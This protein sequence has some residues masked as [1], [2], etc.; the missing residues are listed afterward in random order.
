[1]VEDDLLRL[2]TGL[3]QLHG[4]CM[5]VS[6][7][8]WNLVRAPGSRAPSPSASVTPATENDGGVRLLERDEVR[9]NASDN[10]THDN[11]CFATGKEDQSFQYQHPLSNAIEV[12]FFLHH[13][14]FRRTL[15][16][17][18]GRFEQASVRA[19]LK[20]W[21]HDVSVVSNPNTVSFLLANH[22][23]CL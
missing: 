5:A 3:F 7:V 4:H 16:R 11:P 14:Q 10:L 6:I 8:P 13:R 1:M 17:P 18:W 22:C 12:F 23:S 21:T 15:F 19:R 20:Q 9:W 2:L